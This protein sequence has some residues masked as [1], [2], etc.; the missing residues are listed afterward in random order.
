MTPI[1]FCLSFHAK[2]VIITT[3]NPYFFRSS[4]TQTSPL[5]NALFSKLSFKDA[6]VMKCC[7]IT[8]W[9]ITGW[10]TCMHWFK[11]KIKE[12]KTRC[13]EWSTRPDPLSRHCFRLKFVL[14]WKVGT[15]RRTDNMFKNNYHYPPWLWVG[16]VD[17]WCL[18]NL[19]Q[20]C[21]KLICWHVRNKTTPVE[22]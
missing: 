16:L 15:D 3:G 7:S 13:R 10:R 17:Q 18:K 4:K 20:P 11:L 5:K 6:W 12:D 14:F 1:L 19:I 2:C 21:R 8:G 9:Q 22:A